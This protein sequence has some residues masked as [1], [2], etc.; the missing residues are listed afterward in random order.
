VSA[1]TIVMSG[2]TRLRKRP[3]PVIV[4]PV[5]TPATNTSIPPSVCSQIS[6]PVVASCV[7]G[8]T[9]L[10]YWFGWNAPGISLARRSATE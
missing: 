5:P 2:F 7:S 9:W 1:P 6:G 8:F 10:K 4:P 3:T